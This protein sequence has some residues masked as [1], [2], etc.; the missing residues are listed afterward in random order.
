MQCSKAHETLIITI[1]AIPI[2][3]EILSIGAL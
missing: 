2:I 1:C 3:L